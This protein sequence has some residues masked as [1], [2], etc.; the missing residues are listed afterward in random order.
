MGGV[1][2]ECG[3]FAGEDKSCS[4]IEGVLEDMALEAD[5][6]QRDAIARIEG[7]L[8]SGEEHVE[9]DATDAQSLLSLVSRYRSDLLR[10]IAPITDPFEQIE[11][12]LQANPDLDPTAAKYGKSIGWKL[13]CVID[14]EKAF[15]VSVEEDK[16]V[17]LTWD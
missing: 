12:D 4:A 3:S 11:R 1:Y 15:A 6:P 13:Y 14:L 9:I 8:N 7:S 16:P 5:A 17:I 10:R 2:I